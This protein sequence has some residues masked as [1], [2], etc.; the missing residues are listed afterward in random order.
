MLEKSKS[1]RDEME[2]QGRTVETNLRI[3]TLEKAILSIKF[4]WYLCGDLRIV[5]DV[6][7]DDLWLAFNPKSARRSI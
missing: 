3:L 2:L 7:R 1:I 6:A 5:A 4:C